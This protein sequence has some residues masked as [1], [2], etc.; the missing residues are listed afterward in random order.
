[1]GIFDVFKTKVSEAADKAGDVAGQA[2]K[3]ASDLAGEAK[4]KVSDM[5]DK[6][7]GGGPAD[8]P[9]AQTPSAPAGAESEASAMV[10]EGGP[11]AQTGEAAPGVGDDGSPAADSMGADSMGADSM[12]ADSAGGG[13]TQSIKDNVASGAEKAGDK[14]DSGVQQAKDRLG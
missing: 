12:G 5:V 10:S 4:D 9:S 8:D 3:K 11:V 13:M 1:M 6:K 7:K 2:A 14:L